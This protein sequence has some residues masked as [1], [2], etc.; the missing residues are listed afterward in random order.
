[1]RVLVCISNVPDTTTKIRFKDNNT[2]LYD[3]GIQW[4]I[5]PW[6]ELALT[7]AVELKEDNGSPVNEVV[8]ITVGAMHTEPTLRKCLAIGA[9]K[10]VRIDLEP[11]DAYETACQ[12]EAYIKNEDF[13]FIVCGIESGDYNEASVGGMLAE[14]LDF[15][16]V[17]SVSSIRFDGGTPI[18]QRDV[19]N[20]KE[21]LSVNG[22]AVLIV[23][24]GFAQVPKIPN[25]RG[26]MTARSKALEVIKSIK[27]SPLVKFQSYTVPPA[28]GAVKM[29]KSAGDLVELLSK[30]AKL[31]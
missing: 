7:R 30:E 29:V 10:A 8:V 23:Q 18:F 24:K 19:A 21:E 13:G 14:L 11:L 12:L 27:S 31:I 6:D 28:K 17:S 3:N 16:S 9:D 4:V 22:T 1:M 15:A 25:M 5:N 20:G 26:I 2:Q